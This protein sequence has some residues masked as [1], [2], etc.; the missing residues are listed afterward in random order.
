[1]ADLPPGA[2]GTR[3][4]IIT[5]LTYV[6]SLGGFTHIIGGVSLVAGLMYAPVVTEGV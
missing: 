2:Q 5:M 4:R 6:V 1:M 3:L